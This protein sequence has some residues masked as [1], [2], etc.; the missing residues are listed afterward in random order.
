MNLPPTCLR[1][2]AS[3]EHSNVCGVRSSSSTFAHM[4][5]LWL[6]LSQDSGPHSAK[7]ME[8]PDGFTGAKNKLGC[9]CLRTQDLTAPRTAK[10]MERPD[11]FTGGAKHKL[12]C[13]C[14]RTQ[15]SG[16]HS[17]KK[18]ARRQDL[19]VS[20]AQST[21]FGH[22][23]K[24]ARPDGFTFHKRKAQTSEV[25]NPLCASELRAQSPQLL[26]GTFIRSD[27][28]TYCLLQVIYEA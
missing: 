1:R 2:T 25:S 5:T 20:Q 22:S 26:H 13:A 19:M 28:L 12:G 7:N 21:N 10:N 14:L 4:L 3:A 15:D 8:R 17:A 9:A 11:G 18:M 6:R 16:P 23:A 27:T 24:M